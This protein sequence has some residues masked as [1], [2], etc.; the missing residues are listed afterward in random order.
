MER[1]CLDRIVVE[2]PRVV[3]ATGGGI[4]AEAGTYE[5]LLASFFTIWLE[6]T[7][8][9][10]FERVLAQ[11]DARIAS[12]HMRSEA[13]DNIT[14]TLKA[15]RHLYELAHASYD[16]SGKPVERIV[17]DLLDVRARAESE[18]QSNN[19]PDENTVWSRT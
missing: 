9:I 11:H 7:P 4:V 5:V 13:I 18:R 14:G 17:A 8:E 16:T 3:L 1:E 19:D 2:Y 12:A 6:A 15:R 10:M